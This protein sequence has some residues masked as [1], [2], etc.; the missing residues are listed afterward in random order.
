[1]YHHP[2]RAAKTGRVVARDGANFGLQYSLQAQATPVIER[3]HG[4]QG[5]PEW[6]QNPYSRESGSLTRPGSSTRADNGTKYRHTISPPQDI[7]R[8]PSIL[9]YSHSSLDAAQDSKQHY[10]T[11]SFRD[12][13][14]VQRQVLQPAPAYVTDQSA[15]A[16]GVP[17]TMSQGKVTQEGSYEDSLQ[18]RHSF[19]AGSQ[20]QSRNKTQVFLPGDRVI[21]AESPSAP[22]VPI[23]YRLPEERQANPDR[24]NLDRRR[25]TTCPILE[26]EDYLRLLNFQ[27]NLISK[28]SHLENLKRLIFLDF[29]DN[30]IEEISGL[31]ALRSLR[32]LM[33]GKNRIRK[34]SNLESLTKLDVLDLHGNKIVKIENLGHLTELRVLNLAGNEIV[35]VCNVSGMRALAEL[36]LRRNKI[37][38]VEE[39]DLL[40]NLQRLFLSFNCISSFDDILCLANSTS[41]NELSM[42]GNP[43]AVDQTYKQV[44]LRNL[45]NLRQ[46]DMKR[47][48]EEEKRIASV[49][50]RKEEE[51]KK[52]ISKL[53]V[54]KEKRRIAINNAQRQWEVIRTKQ[55]VKTDS[56]D[57]LE[58]VPQTSHN[59]PTDCIDTRE[60]VPSPL[61]ICHL[62]ELDNDTLYLYGPG[63]LDAL[64]RNWGNQAVQAV[65]AISFK[66]I[67]FDNIVPQ[68]YKIRARFPSLLGLTFTETNIKGLQQINCLSLLK[69]LEHLCISSEGNP[70]TSFTL[71][72]PYILFRL[73]HFS[74]RKINDI[75]VTAEDNVNAEK[76][77]GTLAHITTSQLPQSRLLTMLGDS[78]RKQVLEADKSKKPEGKH[79]RAPSNESV[80]RAGLQYWPVDSHRTHSQEAEERRTFAVNYMKEIAHTAILNERKKKKLN[81]ILPGLFSKMVQT[82]VTDLNDLDTFMKK[83]F[84]KV[85]N[86]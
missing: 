71:W 44:I 49:M 72:K 19:S 61:S 56:R 39:V 17:I 46:L 3:P 83:S 9:Q 37:C 23:V 54:L 24:L 20:S 38:T 7:E 30:Q 16:T 74:L 25:L 63:S 40:P 85:K 67:D 28:I 70:I 15:P 6:K 79:E 86:K 65:Q 4:K 2:S 36:N 53:A 5:G 50:A 42:D 60:A 14:K 58:T 77:F 73:A 27:H 11:P 43:F 12:L 68:L 47:I 13:H 81:E 21:F 82:A 57:T 75:E 59:E 66:F 51:K 35:N 41:L 80:S 29:Y 26:G 62:A 76:L 22:G 18:G 34:I 10:A 69:R 55:I 45:S 48:S 1:M 32:V 8:P 64:D 31:S 52:E 84:E 78:R 33:L